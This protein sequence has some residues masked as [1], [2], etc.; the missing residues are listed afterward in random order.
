MTKKLF[1]DSALS[2]MTNLNACH[3]LMYPNLKAVNVWK[4]HWHSLKIK[5]TSTLSKKVH[6]FGTP[7]I[8][9]FP[10]IK[11]VSYL[12]LLPGYWLIYFHPHFIQYCSWWFLDFF[13]KMF[14]NKTECLIKNTSGCLVFLEARRRLLT[15][16]VYQ[17]HKSCTVQ[18]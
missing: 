3:H 2:R 12:I 14:H 17:R 11:I 15:A 13:A 8:H 9:L 1:L 6:V 18:V 5:E 16:E 7:C 10:C 4:F